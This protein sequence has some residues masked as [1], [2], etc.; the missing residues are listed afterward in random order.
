MDTTCRDSLREKFAQS[1]RACGG[2]AFAIMQS[3]KAPGI[4]NTVSEN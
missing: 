2:N 1:S 3:K 4:R